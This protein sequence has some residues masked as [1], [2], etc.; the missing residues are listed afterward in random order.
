[1]HSPKCLPLNDPDNVWS[2]CPSIGASL[3][4]ASLFGIT[5]LGHI[6]QSIMYRKF[7]CAVVIM[8]ALWELATFIFRSINIYEPTNQNWYQIWFILIL[9]APLWI[10][11]FV[12][13][14]MGRLVYNFSAKQKIWII[15]AHRFGQCFVLLDIM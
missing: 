7:Y 11:A 3:L 15:P 6:V 1:M 14:I 9:V 5:L 8:G 10:N 4:F 12:Y 13:M 2:F